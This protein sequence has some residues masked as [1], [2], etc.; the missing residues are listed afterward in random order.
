MADGAV[1]LAEAADLAKV[2]ARPRRPAPWAGTAADRAAAGC[3]GTA[4][5]HR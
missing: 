4:R 1:L 2:R 3:A 5:R